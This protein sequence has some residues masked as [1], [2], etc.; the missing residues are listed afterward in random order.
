MGRTADI[1]M[2]SVLRNIGRYAAP[3]ASADVSKPVADQKAGAAGKRRALADISN[4][5]AGEES[6]ADNNAAKKPIFSLMTMGGSSSSASEA[7]TARTAVDDG[8]DYMNRESDDIDARDAGNPLLATCY[9]NEMYQH[10]NALER[11]YAVNAN[12]MSNQ[13]YVNERMRAILVDWLVRPTSPVLLPPMQMLVFSHP[14]CCSV[15]HS[16]R[17]RCTSSSRWCRRRCT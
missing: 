13:P 12:Y 1:N 11:Q 10:F 6:K 7:P 2:S 4:A 5:Y 14:S 3:A 17:S 16:C 8:R 9:V 15:C